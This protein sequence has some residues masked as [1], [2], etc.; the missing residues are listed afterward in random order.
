MHIIRKTENNVNFEFN[1]S[2]FKR[3]KSIYNILFK[4]NKYCYPAGDGISNKF[5]NLPIERLIILTDASI[6]EL[7]KW[8][9][10]KNVCVYSDQEARKVVHV[11]Y[12]D[13]DIH[14]EFHSH[15][16]DPIDY[17]FVAHAIAL[18]A[19]IM[20]D[21][22]AIAVD[23]VNEEFIAENSSFYSIKV[24]EL[25]FKYSAHNPNNFEPISTE[26]ILRTM[27]IAIVKNFTF[28]NYS[29]NAII[30]SINSY[31]F[32]FNVD[33]E[34]LTDFLKKI[35]LHS[36]I[37]DVFMDMPAFVSWIIPCLGNCYGEKHNSVWHKHNIY[38]HI[39]Y[40]TDDCKS[41]K[42][43]V[44]L[45]ALLHD[46]GKPLVRVHDDEYNCDHFYNHPE[47]SVELAK[48]FIE[49]RLA[50]SPEETKKVLDLVELHDIYINPNKKSIKK[51]IR[52]YGKEFVQDWAQLKQAD[53]FDHTYP[54]AMKDKWCELV[55][56]Y[57]EFCSN[58]DEVIAEEEKLTVKKLAVN[59]DD[60]MQ[61]LNIEPG[62]RIGYILSLILN[63]VINN[64]YKNNRPEL[65]K[66]LEKQGYYYAEM[67][68]QIEIF[69]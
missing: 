49:S 35:L 32:L 39:L 27:Y 16:H 31:S 23:L 45:A 29:A 67:S 24:K 8:F 50:L 44:K 20:L 48:D 46:I 54:S 52:D 19:S 22:D 55:D 58:L 59:G 65:L 14:Y 4:Y 7:K 26:V 62:P 6:D 33:K 30:R 28:D 5:L 17:M 66:V 15:A 25:N 61:I 13:D 47:K 12:D 1:V 41:D 21:F 60:V 56:R 51:F 9:K 63:D 43:E 64:K 68:K 34:V 37:K 53:L 40:V 38:E 10:G 36:N 11:K 57:H 3:L 2:D 42:F 18:D 69:R